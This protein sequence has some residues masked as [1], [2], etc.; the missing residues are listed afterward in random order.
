MTR[1]LPRLTLCAGAILRWHIVRRW[2]PQLADANRPV[3]LLDIGCG[4]G[5][6][7]FEMARAF[8]NASVVIGVDERGRDDL[9]GFLPIPNRLESQVQLR[10]GWFTRRLVGDNAPFDG[11]LC[12][13]VLEHVAD[14]EAF[15]SE[16][17]AVSAPA[18]RLLLHVPANPQFHSIA[19][20]RRQLDRM[21]A[22]GTG[23]HVREGYSSCAL[24]VLLEAAGWRILR[25]R[26]TFGRLA[27]WWCD[28]DFHLAA[29]GSRLVRIAALPAT[30]AGGMVTSGWPPAQGNGWL[31]L[32]ER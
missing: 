23:Q 15:V 1:L 13:D 10:K 32:A 24:S 31:L 25:I 3:R 29:R 2:L 6:Y 11:I 12:V 30:I 21:L 16:I 9:A 5:E 22:E 18:A 8:P 17:A 7:V 28:A 27:A 4:R 19:P 20:V 26:A 14:D